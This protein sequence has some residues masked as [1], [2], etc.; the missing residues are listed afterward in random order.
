[1]ID[2]DSLKTSNR[3]LV[4]SPAWVGD[5]VMAQTLYK[6]LRQKHPDTAIDVLAP[7]A[8]LPLVSRMAEVSRGIRFDLGHGELGLGKRKMIGRSLKSNAYRKAII[9]PNS[10]KSALVPFH[11]DIAMRTGFRGEYRYGLINDM[12]ML[13]KR[14]LP[15]M[16]DRFA[17]LGVE[18]GA[19]VPK[20]EN[21]SLTVNE[22]KREKLIEKFSLSL[23]K[24]ILAICPGAEF[25][26][27]KKWPENHYAKLADQAI[28]RGMQVW[29]FG[30]PKDQ[31][32]SQNI[33]ALINMSTLEFCIDLTGK[34]SL[35]DVIDLLSLCAMVVS[36][37]SGLMHIAAAVGCHTTV[38]YG[39]TSPEFTP[40]LTNKLEIVSLNLSCSPCFKRDCPL[41]HKA[42]LVD[43]KPESLIPIIEAHCE[44]P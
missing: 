3:I 23:E 7:P 39:S 21:P 6:V 22:H 24:P 25:G 17:S 40:P 30:G 27:A 38:I 13:N 4:V 19:E 35:L 32:T 29:I 12:R 8:T 18:I 14:T 33:R 26:D 43:L 41:K 10:L 5:M 2:N 42:C 28:E 34:T 31:D 16:I 20:L 37:D 9:L 1:M 44:S 36:N 11:A 15:R